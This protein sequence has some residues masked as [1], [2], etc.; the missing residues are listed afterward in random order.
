MNICILGSGIQGRVV[1]QDLAESNHQ[2]TV[3]DNNQN[4]LKKMWNHYGLQLNFLMS[5][6]KKN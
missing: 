4:N 2:V 3:I 5:Q 6:I 1:A